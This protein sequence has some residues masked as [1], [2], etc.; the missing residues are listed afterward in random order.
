MP[1][2]WPRKKFFQASSCQME[3]SE[4]FGERLGLTVGTF[5]VF[6]YPSELLNNISLIQILK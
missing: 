3:S 6:I 5:N 1:A 2:R 4:K